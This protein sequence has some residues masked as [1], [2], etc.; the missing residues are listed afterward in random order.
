MKYEFAHIKVVLLNVFRS[1]MHYSFTY[2]TP[3][4][5]SSTRSYKSHVVL[6]FPT[7][8]AINNSL[9]VY[10]ELISL[11]EREEEIFIKSEFDKRRTRLG[12]PKPE[13]L[14]KGIGIKV[15][16]SSKL[17]EIV[18]GIVTIGIPDE[19]A[20][21]MWF[22]GRDSDTVESLGLAYIKQFI[23]LFP[24]SAL[25]LML[26]GYFAYSKVTHDDEG[27][28]EELTFAVDSDPCDIILA[29]CL[30]GTP[31]LA[32][33]EHVDESGLELVRRYESNIA[34]E[35]REWSTQGLSHYSGHIVCPPI[36]SQA[37]PS[38]SLFL[39]RHPQARTRL[40]GPEPEQLRT[41]LLQSHGGML[42]QKS[43]CSSHNAVNMADTKTSRGLAATGVSTIICV[44]HN[45]KL[46][47]GVGDHKNFWPEIG[48][49]VPIQSLAALPPNH[50]L[51]RFFQQILFVV[52]SS[53]DHNRTPLHMS[54]KIVQ[55]LYKSSSQ[56][57]REIYAA[58][59]DQPCRTFEDVAK[60]PITW[61][62]CRAQTQ[63][64][65]HCDSATKRSCQHF[66]SGST[67]SENFV[68]RS[69]PH[70]P[71]VASQS[72][73]TYPVEVLVQLAQAGDANEE[74]NSLLE[75]LRVVC[76]PTTEGMVIRQPS[77]KPETEQL[78][79][80][81][82]SWFQQW[83]SIF[84][85]SHPG[86]GFRPL[87]LPAHEAGDFEGRR[88]FFILLP[89]VCGGKC[90]QLHQMHGKR[91]V[92]YAFQV[93]DSMSRL[94]VYIIKYHGDA[95]GIDNDQAKVQHLTKILSIFVLV[96][97]NMHEEQVVLFQQKPFFRLFSSLI[98]DLH[99]IAEHLG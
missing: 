6:N 98:S 67:A 80:K 61:L 97:A 49:I 32:A 54:Q 28:T 89:R 46:T 88:L 95:S 65:C 48:E 78:K 13:Q 51:R 55:L 33:S 93:L 68:Y 40:G 1:F 19:F 12:G 47:N 83:V 90:E 21:C 44:C 57:G 27:S 70:D 62:L 69:S 16:H 10:E 17:D 7:Q 56:L 91:R 87:H 24:T 5:T 86:E 8:S 31:G 52:A 42:Q 11:T 63:H 94:I 43:T 79:E 29:R 14:R 74:V 36:S 34:R 9:A 30:F 75:H 71:P 37:P 41:S 84:Q 77:V 23:E 58:L 96:L 50:D 2:Q 81:L 4:C 64:P 85:R 99:S 45:M 15:W 26:T 39:K 35:L 82:F 3:L 92:E 38:R 59:L 76:R 20:W 72:Q 60:E 22:E 66:A 73:L 53:I 25:A 18:H